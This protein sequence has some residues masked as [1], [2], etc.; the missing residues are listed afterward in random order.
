VE[1]TLTIR[2]KASGLLRQLGDNSP[3]QVEKSRE[4]SDA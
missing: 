4:A 2:E 3:E 1:L